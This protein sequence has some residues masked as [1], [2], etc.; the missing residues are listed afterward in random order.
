MTLDPL[1]LPRTN[2]MHHVEIVSRLEGEHIDDLEELVEAATGVDHHEPLGEHKFLRLQRGDDLGVAM[3]AYEGGEL[4]GYAHT[5]AYGAPEKRRV[6]CE[7]VVHPEHRRIGIGTALLERVIDH[8]RKQRALRLDLWAY[9][10]SEASRRFAGRLSLSESRRLLHMHR[11]PG[12]PPHLPA[13]N[14]ARLRALRAGDEDG[15]LVAL[16]NHIFAFHPEQG[17]WTL[18]DLRARMRRPWF[19]AQDVL[20]LEV[21]GALAGFCWLKVEERGTEGRVGE[22]YVIGTAPEYQGRGLG[23]YLLSE[24]LQHAS[25]RD[26]NAVAVYVDEQ[27]SAAVR[28][29]ASFEFHHHHVDVCYT[30]ALR[31]E[32]G[33]STRGQAGERPGAAATG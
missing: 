9:N 29:Y 21:D 26:V 12:E 33:V 14:G 16:N 22:I 25:T 13:P 10:D 2:T 1:T 20:M 17:Q 30:L 31:E 7:F 15:A 28:L 23:R 27:N 24:A 32:A 5:L 11:H 6:S 8:A 18:D 19:D 3:L 4:V